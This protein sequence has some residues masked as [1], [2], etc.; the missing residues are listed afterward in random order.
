MT[1]RNTEHPDFITDTL[2]IIYVYISMKRKSAKYCATHFQYLSLISY[3]DCAIK[4]DCIQLLFYKLFLCLIRLWRVNNITFQGYFFF[5]KYYRLFRC[6]SIQ[7]HPTSSQISQ[8][9]WSFRMSL[10]PISYPV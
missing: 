9:I 5:V 8:C 7:Q 10:I 1:S 6:W 4:N 3:L 2:A